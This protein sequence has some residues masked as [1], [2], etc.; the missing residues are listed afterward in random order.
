VP[1][2][3]AAR[4]AARSSIRWLAEN[5][6]APGIIKISSDKIEQLPTVVL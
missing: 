3:A 6:P 1:A 2:G 4:L 5:G